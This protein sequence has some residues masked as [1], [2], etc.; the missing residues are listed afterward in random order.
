MMGGV[1]ARAVLVPSTTNGGIPTVW[2]L[3]PSWFIMDL[4][5]EAPDSWW[6]QNTRFF[7]PFGLPPIF[8]YHIA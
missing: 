3:A 5:H 4:S 7:Y 1:G 6:N 2:A 8:K